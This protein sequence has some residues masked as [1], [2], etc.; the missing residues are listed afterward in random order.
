MFCHALPELPLFF[1]GS[2]VRQLGLI[3]SQLLPISMPSLA[4]KQAAVLG[5]E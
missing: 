5:R 4:I 2:S 3:S 1:S